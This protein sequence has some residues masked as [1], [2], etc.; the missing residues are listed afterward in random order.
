MPIKTFRGVIPDGGQERIRL[1]H[2]DGKTGY[3]MVKFQILPE[4]P[5]DVQQESIVQAWKTNQLAG[6]ATIPTT[7]GNIDFSNQVLLGAIVGYYGAVA[8]NN[9]QRQT[10]IFDT[11][12]F[13]QDIYVTHT[14][15]ASNQKVNYYLELEKIKLSDHEAMVATIQNIRNG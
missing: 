8:S 5:G 9:S 11:E 12:V 10:V 15:N 4:S 7:A 1:K 13:N 6:G 2:I 3:R 14:D